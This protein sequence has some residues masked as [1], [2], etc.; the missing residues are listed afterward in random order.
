MYRGA[1]NLFHLESEEEGD[2]GDT[3]EQIED[4]AIDILNDLARAQNDIVRVQSKLERGQQQMGELLTQLVANTQ[5]NQNIVV[6][7]GSR[8]TNKFHCYQH[9]DNI[10]M[11]VILSSKSRSMIF[12]DIFILTTLFFILTTFSDIFRYFARCCRYFRFQTL[13]DILPMPIF[14]TLL[15]TA[16]VRMETLLKGA[17]H[18]S[19]H[20]ITL[21]P[22]VE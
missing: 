1:G 19:L 20:G 17:T 7:D 16:M 2:M 13:G 14:A 5:G 21:G 6:S 12:S 15:I 9:L 18:M 3:N 10:S 8:G 4:N 22:L 11:L